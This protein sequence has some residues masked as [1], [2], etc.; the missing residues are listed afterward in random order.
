M[1]SIR[2]TKLK[3]GDQWLICWFQAMDLKWAMPLESRH[4]CVHVVLGP[5]EL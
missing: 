4:F 1:D 3:L 5:L 2:L